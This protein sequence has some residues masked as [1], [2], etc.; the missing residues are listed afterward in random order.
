[1]VELKDVAKTKTWLGD[2]TRFGAHIICDASVAV[3][4]S[5]TR[6]TPVRARFSVTVPPERMMYF[7]SYRC[8]QT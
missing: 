2:K 5:I 3:D 4:A 1:M 6:S 8:P 7:R